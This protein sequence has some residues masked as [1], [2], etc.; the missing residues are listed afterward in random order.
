METKKIVEDLKRCAKITRMEDCIGCNYKRSWFGC[1]HL[2]KIDAADRLE[3][4]EREKEN[5]IHYNADLNNHLNKAESHIEKLE[6]QLSEQQTEWISVEDRLPEEEGQY[7]VCQKGNAIVTSSYSLCKKKWFHH[8]V[9]HWMP[10][11]EPP[12]PKEPTF[13]DVFL[14]KFP[15]AP[16]DKDGIPKACIANVFPWAKHENCD[17]WECFEDWNQSYFELKEEGEGDA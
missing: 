3:E 9:T 12:K 4:L 11:P 2:I 6:K 8:E 7:L 5:L 15:K 13:K 1:Y 16:V 10:L 17:G 14:E